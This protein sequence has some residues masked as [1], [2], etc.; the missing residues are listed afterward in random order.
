MDIAV[1]HN[2]PSGGH[3]R[4][5]FEQM[6]ILAKRH[7]LDLFT[8]SSA[9]KSFLDLS[10][11]AN[12]C[13][14]V[15]YNYPKHFPQSVISIYRDLPKA[16]RKL[17]DKINLGCYNVIFVNPCF[18]TQAPYILK[19]LK[20]PTVYFCAETRREFYEKIPRQIKRFNYFMTY[21]FRYPIKLV[22]RENVKFAGRVIVSSNFAKEK[23]DEAY[24][25]SSDVN[26]LG[27]D[28]NV[29]KLLNL[30]KENMVLTVGALN[31]LKGHDFII[32]SLSLIPQNLRPKLVIV[33]CSGVE[34]NYLMKLALNKKVRLEVKENI[35]DSQ[36]VKLYNEAKLF[37]F[38]ALREPFGLVLLEAASCGLPILAVNEGGSVEIVSGEIGV[39]T[40]R[41][42]FQ[43]ALKIREMLK[44]KITFEEKIKRHN[45]VRK[46]WS[47]QK[48]VEKLEFYLDQT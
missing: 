40:K 19:Y 48:S 29:F 11:F 33:G 7:T 23:V 1:V 17:A 37:L 25:V 43:F 3:K 5:L 13:Y 27:V 34:K 36:L 45:F 12:R 35:T 26:Y 24:G 10:Q 42:E 28:I 6:K 9:D 14:E 18:L 39:L 8:L 20:A 2:L 47:W 30:K 22:D 46:N 21:P 15:K 16:Y 32:N 41:N 38:A 44:N 4:A 31:L